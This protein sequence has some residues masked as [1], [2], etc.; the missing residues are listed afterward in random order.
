MWSLITILFS[1]IGDFQL[2]PKS[3][4]LFIQLMLIGIWNTN[5]WQILMIFLLLDINCIARFEHPGLLNLGHFWLQFFKKW[6]IFKTSNESSYSLEFFRVV[7]SC[8]SNSC[9]LHRELSAR[10]TFSSNHNIHKS[11]CGLFFG[12]Q[13]GIF[14]NEEVA[15]KFLHG[16][17]SFLW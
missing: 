6:R 2:P 11:S 10:Y 14:Q 13:P 1:K 16:K 15:S 12:L 8:Q 7:Q 9:C 4:S 3:D 5:F 17:N